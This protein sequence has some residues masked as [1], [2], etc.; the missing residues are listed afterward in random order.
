MYEA[1]DLLHA[2]AEEVEKTVFF[3]T[4]NLLNLEVELIFYE[5]TTASFSV[6]F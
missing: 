5:T 6:D 1:M 2:H 4:A 3:Q